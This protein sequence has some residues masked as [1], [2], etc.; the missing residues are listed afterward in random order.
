MTENGS[1]TSTYT[2][3]SL[4][5]Q[6]ACAA[7]ALKKVEQLSGIQ[8]VIWHALTDNNVEGNLNLG[9]HYRKDHPGDP[10]GKKPSWYVYQAYGTANESKVLDQYLPV[11]GVSKW[12]DIIHSV[13]D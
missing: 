11:I 12:E 10:W 4:K 5:E 13:S 6:A 7:Y 8:T 3:Q 2:E 1:S 9:L